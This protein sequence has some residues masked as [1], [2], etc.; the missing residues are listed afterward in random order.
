MSTTSNSKTVL[1]RY[2]AA[3]LFILCCWA[4]SSSYSQGIISDALSTEQ[5]KLIHGR[6][7]APPTGPKFTITFND[8]GRFTLNNRTGQYVLVDNQLH[9]TQDRHTSVYAI[10]VGPDALELSGA[11]LR[12]SLKLTR[13]KSIQSA[14]GLTAK[15]LDISSPTFKAKIKKIVFILIILALARLLI[16]LLHYTSRI[17]IFSDWGPLAHIYTKNKNRQ[18]TIHSIILNLLKYFIYFTALGFVLTEM[19]IDYTAYLA[20]LSV[21]GLAIGFGSQGL[22]QDFVTGFFIVF[23]GQFQVGDMVEISGQTG[24]VEE[25]GLRMTKIR[26]YLGQIV[27]LPNRAIGVVGTFKKGALEAYIDIALTEKL[28]KATSLAKVLGNELYLQF[29][30]I[31]LS[32]P[33]VLEPLKLKTGEQFLRIKLNLWPQQ[34]WLAEQQ[35]VSRIKKL[36]EPEAISIPD[37]RVIIF[38]HEPKPLKSR[39]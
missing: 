14:R 13:Q 12:Q 28:D 9:L 19:G 38:Y 11:G 4:S 18:L 27:C 35:F 16:S 1:F 24:I 20:S 39:K 23:E 26:N 7:S 22:V 10:D 3:F 25:L 34:Q 17:I 37:D 2:F 21:I 36:F 31:L 6:W 32:I 15:W 30:E 29:P 5:Q 8:K 33:E